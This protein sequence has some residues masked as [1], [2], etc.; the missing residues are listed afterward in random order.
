VLADGRRKFGSVARC[1]RCFG[2]CD[3]GGRPPRSSADYRDFVRLFPELWVPEGPSSAER[4]AE[5]IAPPHALVLR[6]G[7]AV[8]GFAWARPRGDRPHVSIVITDP[9]HRRQGVA[10]TLMTAVAE[11]GRAAGFR[12]WMLNVKPHNT[13]ARTLYERCGMSVVLASVYRVG[14][15]GADRAPGRNRCSPAATGRRC[16]VR[17]RSG[18]LS[19]RTLRLSRTSGARLVGAEG[20][21][22]PVGVV[23]YDPIHP[24]VPLLRVRLPRAA[25]RHPPLRPPGPRLRFRVRFGVRRPGASPTS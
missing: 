19:R 7:D 15:C 2:S 23:A 1:H 16:S 11:Q 21:D 22:G 14:G 20:P 25:R 3:R 13:A 8:L 6:D 4:F 10:R 17:G 12:R 9:A 24:G 5:W 18:A